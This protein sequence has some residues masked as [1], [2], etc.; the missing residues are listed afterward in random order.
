M[1]H[2][3][4][5][6]CTKNLPFENAWFKC[7]VL[8]LA[9]SFTRIHELVGIGFLRPGMILTIA[10]T[11]FFIQSNRFSI[12]F[13]KQILLVCLFTALLIVFVPFAKNNYFA[14]QIAKG[15]V[16]M[17]PFLFSIA[18]LIKD[19][20]RL[21]RLIWLIVFF[22]AFVAVYGLTHSGRGVSGVVADENDLALFLVTFLPFS[23]FLLAQR[24]SGLKKIM[25][26]SVIALSILSVVATWSRG[27]FV[28]L[29]AMLGV[30][31]WFS[32]NKAKVLLFIAVLVG[33]L[34]AYGGE[35]YIQ[36]ISGI[37]ETGGGTAQG[38]I[39]SW[40]AGWHMFLDHPLGVGGNN[41]P[42]HFPDYQSDYFSREMWGRVAHSLWFTLIP[43][44]GIIGI[45][46]FLCLLKTNVKNICLLR[47]FRSKNNT[48]DYSD[49]YKKYYFDLST[50]F[51][52]SFVGFF[53]A[54]TFLSVLYYP[55]FWLLTVLVFSVRNISDRELQQTQQV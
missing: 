15:M 51:I 44:T 18:I 41:F 8:Y 7:L 42:M 50:A 43:E 2:A 5:H 38:R 32:K 36:E 27:G 35:E 37:T 33:V 29:V 46:I 24:P 28:G 39:Q 3:G 26:L 53:A 19:L 52:A 13:N 40:K 10:L 4:I 34:F 11:F 14:F 1:D 48:N 31:F 9:V 23:F 20:H 25:L 47:K 16:L 12:I 30:Y 6:S 21:H 55:H 54:G 45:L 17:L 49:I 22:T